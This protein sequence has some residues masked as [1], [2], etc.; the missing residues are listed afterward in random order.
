MYIFG[1]MRSFDSLSSNILLSEMLFVYTLSAK[2]TSWNWPGVLAFWICC[3][4][5]RFY[6]GYCNLPRFSIRYGYVLESH[7][8]WR[9]F[10]SLATLKSCIYHIYV[11]TL[12]CYECSSDIELLS[13]R[14]IVFTYFHQA[15]FPISCRITIVIFVFKLW[16][17]G[18]CW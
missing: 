8:V 13:G 6:F 7:K 16:I 14:Y 4:Y 17:L 9:C 5:L 10:T 2:F 11:Y 18:Q 1:R 15:L 12:Y 3:F